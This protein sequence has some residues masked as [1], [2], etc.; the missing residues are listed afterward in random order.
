MARIGKPT[1]FIVDGSIAVTG[2]LVSAAR[3][4]ELLK[5]EVETILVLPRG[6]QV[7]AARTAAFAEV[8]DLPIVNLRKSAAS[9]ILYGPSLIAASVM[10]WRAMRR[11]GCERLQLNDFY[12]LH[13]AVLRLLGFRGRIVTFVRI[14]PTR[15]GIA[16]RTW[17]AAARWSSTG[18][19][20]V[21]RFIQRLLQPAFPSRLLYEH[22]TPGP[23]AE[24]P[25]ASRP[26]ILLF[27]GNFIEGKGQ[28]HAIEAFHRIADRCPAARLRFVGGDMGLDKN[29]LFRSA[30]EQA[31]ADGPAPERIEFCGHQDDLRA[32]YAE[33]FAALNFSASES[34]SNTC[35]DASA[36]GLAVVAT[37]CGGPEE[38]IEDGVTGFLVPVGD[39]AAMAERMM[40]LL[41]HPDQ[42]AAMGAAGRRLVGERFAPERAKSALLAML[43]LAPAGRLR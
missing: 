32:D 20:A 35:L 18:L 11:H 31:A 27:V 34:F 22:V 2:A 14:D 26:P 43:G 13:G 36:A 3:Q 25:A 4:A 7:P 37:R 41:D 30:L 17:L 38:I 33:A 9:L 16:G 28:E 5:D 42:V 23:V 1:L 40:W 15:F 10:L 39:V 8:I 24:G 19:V 29:L 6:H 12:L 21:S